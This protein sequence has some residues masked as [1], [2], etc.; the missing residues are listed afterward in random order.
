M[1]YL[2]S[3]I[4]SKEINKAMLNPTSCTQL[5]RQFDLR[6]ADPEIA[7]KFTHAG[8]IGTHLDISTMAGE[9]VCGRMLLEAIAGAAVIGGGCEGYEK[10]QSLFFPVVE[11]YI[12]A[13]KSEKETRYVIPLALLKYM[14]KSPV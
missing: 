6:L 4:P 1:R 9:D 11:P 10:F 3:L 5:L 8:F 14:L 2:T 12:K 7:L 13:L